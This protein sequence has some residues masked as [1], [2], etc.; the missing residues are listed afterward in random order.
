MRLTPLALAGLLLFG[1]AAAS[2][3][4][5]TG[6]YTLQGQQGV[7]TLSLEQKRGG[8]TTGTL[9]GNGTVIQLTGKVEDG[10]LTGEATSAGGRALFQAALEGGQLAFGLVELGADGMPNMATAAELRF[11]RTSAVATAPPPAAAPPAP[12][13]SGR[14]RA[15][16]PA[17]SAPPPAPPAAPSGSAQD[18]QLRLLLLSSPW[19]SFSYSQT[20][21]STSTSRNVFH[22]DG[23]L[24]VNTNREGGTVNQYGGSS[25]PSGS[26]YSQSQGGGT[27]GWQVRGGQLYL[28]AG[29]GFQQV[30]LSVS[31]NSNGYPI[32][33]ADGK[34]YSQCN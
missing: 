30:P 6:T 3:Q 21:G 23:R 11:T 9:S 32:I 15:G 4:K 20:S 10:E 28:D 29:D 24:S 13:A 7:I 12:P 26:V 34:E 31:R 33:K 2:A 25:T 17:P 18:Q 14:A 16:Q 5:F 22:P 19:C 1:P 27:I 8:A